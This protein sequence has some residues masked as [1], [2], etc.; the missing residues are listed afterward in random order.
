MTLAELTERLL[1]GEEFVF[2]FQDNEYWISQNEGL[3]FL[4]VV[5]ESFSQEYKSVFDLIEEGTLNSIPFKVAFK[6][7]DL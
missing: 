3:F 2:N 5:S 1:N 6:D 4:T 7:I